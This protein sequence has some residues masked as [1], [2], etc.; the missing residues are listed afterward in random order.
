M[1]KYYNNLEDYIKQL[2]NSIGIYHPHQLNMETVST[3]LGIVVHRIPHKSMC[4]EDN[5]FLN[6]A[7]D[8]RECWE[9]FGH[10]LCHAKWHAGNQVF[11]HALMR[12]LQEWKAENF[13]QHLCIPSFMLNQIKLPDHESEA[14]WLIMETFGVTRDFAKKRLEQYLRNLIF[15]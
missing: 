9:E 1:V 13:S 14:I 8:D 10:E 7:L 6:S 2:L 4:V 15:G 5:I 3:R 12:E 11:I